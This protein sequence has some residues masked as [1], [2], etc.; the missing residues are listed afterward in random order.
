VAVPEIADEDWIARRTNQLE[1]N[2]GYLYS[3]IDDWDQFKARELQR[4]KERIPELRQQYIKQLEKFRQYSV[5]PEI[6]NPAKMWKNLN[7]SA[8]AQLELEKR[9]LDAVYMYKEV[10]AVLHVIDNKILG[11]YENKKH[12][13]HCEKATKWEDITIILKSNE[14]VKITTPVGESF[15]TYAELDM[16]DKR[17]GDKPTLLWELL[18]I[19]AEKGGEVSSKNVVYDRRLPDT[20]KRLNKHMMNLFGI[21]ESIYTGHYK[22]KNKYEMRIRMMS[23]TIHAKIAS[24]S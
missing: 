3:D 9:L 21:E 16:S 1:L 19:F 24:P 8:R 12:I 6:L 18:K 15:F 22:S 11:S 20:A 23:D 2:R 13:L 14:M 4:M 7:L 10:N 5:R 17:S